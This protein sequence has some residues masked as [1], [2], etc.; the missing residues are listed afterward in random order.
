MPNINHSIY[1]IWGEVITRDVSYFTLLEQYTHVCYR[2]RHNFTAASTTLLVRCSNIT[3][4]N[5]CLLAFF[6]H[7]MTLSQLRVASKRRRLSRRIVT[8]GKWDTIGVQHKFIAYVW[9]ARK[10]F[11]DKRPSLRMSNVV[12]TKL[13][14]RKLVAILLL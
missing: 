5:V 13:E 9:R 6:S 10:I 8:E 7:L 11:Q 12:P 3:K 4:F 2:H 14:A 1:N